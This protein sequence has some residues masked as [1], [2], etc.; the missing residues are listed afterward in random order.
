M[1]I[2]QGQQFTLVSVSEESCE[3]PGLTTLKGS[4]MA[5]ENSKWGRDTRSHCAKHNAVMEEHVLVLS[6]TKRGTDRQHAA[7]Q[8]RP[9]SGGSLKPL[10]QL[11][12]QPHT[13]HWPTPIPPSL[14]ILAPD[15]PSA[16][17]T[18]FLI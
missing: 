8:P 4:E 6:G 10:C 5:N 9:P 2:N 11:P 12:S 14:R 7:P 16:P 17:P 15:P 1:V 13:A 18:R 3:K